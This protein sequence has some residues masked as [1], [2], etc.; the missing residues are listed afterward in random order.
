M[1]E[2]RDRIKEER[3]RE[4]DE[5]HGKLRAMEKSFESIFQDAFDSLAVKM[6][7][8]RLKWDTE[9][10]WVERNAIQILS[11]FGKDLQSVL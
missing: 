4:V 9:S 2:D 6:E 5:L 7:G 3:D 1:T 10:K 8:S 11:E